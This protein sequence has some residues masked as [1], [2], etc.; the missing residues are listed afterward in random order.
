MTLEGSSVVVIGGSSGIGLATAAMAAQR[1]AH[2]VIG[3][4][5]MDKLQ[6]AVKEIGNAEPFAVDVSDRSSIKKL[7]GALERVDHVFVPGGA[8]VGGRILDLPHEEIE[9]ELRA[10][11]MGA[12]HVAQYA[13]PLMTEGSL[14]FI[15]GQL[16][17]KARVG[18]AATASAGAA[19][20]HLTKVL[21]QELAPIRVNCVSPGLVDTPI[22]GE[23]RARMREGAKK[24]PAG[25]IGSADDISEAVFFL[26][27]ST[28]VTG[29]ILHV[30]GGG[31]FT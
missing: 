8:F 24:L 1:G 16:T 28:Y 3:G 26:M 14:T 30:D 20:E 6:A 23:H 17:S 31:R 27:V 19:V 11:V 10:R 12:V 29:E 25:R 5:S 9:S 22:L 7:F 15:S 2:V 18:T 13:A 21:A 4:R